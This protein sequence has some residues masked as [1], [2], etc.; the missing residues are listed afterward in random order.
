MYVPHDI[1]SIQVT[2]SI[3]TKNIVLWSRKPLQN[4]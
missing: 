3:G 4:S 1:R 2:N